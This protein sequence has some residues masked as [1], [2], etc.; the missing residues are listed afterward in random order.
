LF[1]IMTI[2]PLP[3]WV[4]VQYGILRPESLLSSVEVDFSS[5]EA[6]VSSTSADAFFSFEDFCQTFDHLLAGVLSNLF[7][8]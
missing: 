7:S 3:P 6:H 2:T 4:L 8:Y 1:S 5:E